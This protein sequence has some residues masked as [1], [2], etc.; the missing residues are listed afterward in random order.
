M[1]AG[2][3]K[4][5]AQRSRGLAASILATPRYKTRVRVCPAYI[6][7]LIGPRDRKSVQSIAACGEELGYD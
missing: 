1:E 3:G 4:G 7:G 5:M 2:H 6:A